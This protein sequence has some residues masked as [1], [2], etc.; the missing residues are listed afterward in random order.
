MAECLY[1]DTQDI[2][3]LLKVG[4]HKANEIM[5]I[6]EA[7]GEL[8]KLGKTMRVRKSYFD[9]WLARMDGPEKRR[10]ILDNEFQ[11]TSARRK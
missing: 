1:Y 5:H 10:K 7:R 3:D 11:R 6:F 9:A 8:F 4:K 2:M